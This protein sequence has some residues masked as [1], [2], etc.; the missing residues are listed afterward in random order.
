MGTSID[1]GH[2]S[3]TQQETWSEAG[4][5]R[6]KTTNKPVCSK[7]N[8]VGCPDVGGG[9]G[10]GCGTGWA[11][12]DNGEEIID[13][14]YLASAARTNPSPIPY[15]P[16]QSSSQFMRSISHDSITNDYDPSSFIS[17]STSSSNLGTLSL[18][19]SSSSSSSLTPT[20][21]TPLPS[22]TSMHRPLITQ[23]NARAANLQPIIIPSNFIPS[24]LIPS[25]FTAA[26][27]LVQIDDEFPSPINDYQYDDDI[28]DDDDD[29]DEDDEVTF[30]TQNSTTSTSSSSSSDRSSHRQKSVV[31]PSSLSLT[32]TSTFSSSSSTTSS[33]S[34]PS[35]SS[36]SSSSEDTL[37]LPLH[38]E[39]EPVVAVLHPPF[40][41]PQLTPDLI[42]SATPVILP[43][44]ILNIPSNDGRRIMV[45]I[46]DWIIGRLRTPCVKKC[47][48]AQAIHK[49]QKDGT[50]RAITTHCIRCGASQFHSNYTNRPLHLVRQHHPG[51]GYKH[52]NVRDVIAALLSH[53]GALH[54]CRS[55][56]LSNCAGASRTTFVRLS[57][58]FWHWVEVETQGRLAELRRKLADAGQK[59]DI[60]VDMAWNVRG[61]HGSDGLLVT[62]LTDQTPISLI[63]MSKGRWVI[64]K[65]DN[66]KKK[67][68]KNQKRVVIYG[69]HHASSAAMEPAA[70][71]KL[72]DQLKDS[73]C[74]GLVDRMCMDRDAG[75]VSLYPSMDGSIGEL[76]GVDNIRVRLP[77]ITYPS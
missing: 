44:Q 47:G 41:I 13:H 53:N 52:W 36:S 74:I 45:N 12:D 62:L 68:K 17:S 46:N 38:P 25:S 50:F 66:E 9:G 29:D 24:N 75:C 40:Q 55:K 54:Y 11:V 31:S 4:N 39:A 23:S 56:A 42:R 77:N 69:N 37:Q 51:R 49:Y 1:E 22:P 5:D 35:T 59:F 27:P 26:P 21:V 70:H 15:Q 2:Q 63:H 20:I 32:H 76:K 58:H 10:G 16:N 34:L 48:V 65:R 67:W 8:G 33:S 14:H 64:N 28:Y 72:V 60:S 57:K 30:L 61:H 71:L 3:P 19:S 73:N 43:R 7:C 6:N 18:Q